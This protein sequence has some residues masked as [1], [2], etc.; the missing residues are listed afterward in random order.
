MLAG[1]VLV[2]AS[3]GAASAG[4]ATPTTVTFTYTGKAQ[5]WTVPSQ[6]FSA[7][8]TVYGAQ[9][10]GNAG[11]LGG[12]ATA[13]VLLHP[14]GVIP[15]DVGGNG[16][17][18]GFNGGGKGGS[19]AYRGGGASDVRNG[20]SDTSKE[21]LIGGG[22]GGAAFPN[23]VGVGGGTGGGSTGGNGHSAGSGQGG[24]GGGGTQNAGGGGG[25]AGIA[26]GPGAAGSSGRGGA[27][28][29]GAQDTGGGGGGGGYFGGGG[30]GSSEV[31]QGS[32]FAGGGGGGGSGFGPSGVV[33]H[34]GARVGNGLVTISY[35]RGEPS[36]GELSVTPNTGPP[37]T[38]IDTSSISPCP[39]SPPSG[40]HVT[41]SFVNSSTGQVVTSNPA[42]NLDNA[43]DWNGTLAVPPET[44]PGAYAVTARCITAGVET[45]DYRFVQFTVSPPLTVTLRSNRLMR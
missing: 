18:G 9:G 8:F 22:G 11:G 33:F 45:Q 19:G 3:L 25:A 12:E 10:G 4:A 32:P 43:G 7:S 30:G 44:S 20:P 16:S 40:T 2:T 29:P 13:T 42:A 39:L 36:S 1:T 41:I 37:G 21:F 5:Y 27:G 15:V 23:Q 17:V 24:Y 38:V 34:N 31:G 35:I 26:G 28:A 6:V 14:G